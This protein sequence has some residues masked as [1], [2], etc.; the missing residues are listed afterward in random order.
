MREAQVRA[1]RRDARKSCLQSV[2]SGVDLTS[3]FKRVDHEGDKVR[4]AGAEARGCMALLHK[5]IGPVRALIRLEAAHW[6]AF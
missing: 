2:C 3:L 1:S 5:R 4:S 6:G